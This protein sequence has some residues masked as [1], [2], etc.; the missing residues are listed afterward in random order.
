MSSLAPRR[1]FGEVWSEEACKPRPRLA[2]AMWC[3]L[4]AGASFWLPLAA[5]A[6]AIA[7]VAGLSLALDALLG[8]LDW[9]GEVPDAPMPDTLSTTFFVV[10]LGF[11]APLVANAFSGMLCFWDGCSASC[12]VSGLIAEIYGKVLR[13]PPGKPLVEIQAVQDLEPDSEIEMINLISSNVFHAWRGS[14]TSYAQM[15]AAPAC[16]LVLV[17][18]LILKAGFS[19]VFGS[20]ATL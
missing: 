2:S 9:R 13:L 5:V 10:T 3:F 14:L 18:L 20:L 4:G 12:L 7:E 19:A 15:V 11:A 17:A 16:A 1:P 6:T 8:Y